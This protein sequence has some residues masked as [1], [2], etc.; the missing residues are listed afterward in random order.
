MTH[1]LPEFNSK[2]F[3]PQDNAPYVVVSMANTN[4][5]V[6]HMLKSVQS[7]WGSSISKQKKIFFL[8][9]LDSDGD[10]CDELSRYFEVTISGVVYVQA[11]KDNETAPV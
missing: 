11:K 10:K 1:A 2:G 9:Y 6:Y 7:P 5:T 8:Q 3:F 4:Q